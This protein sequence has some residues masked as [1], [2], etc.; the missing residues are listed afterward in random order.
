MLENAKK[1]NIVL[2]SSSAAN[3]KPSEAKQAFTKPEHNPDNRGEALN[4][5][6]NFKK[7]N[8]TLAEQ[9]ET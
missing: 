9:G 5:K 4:L 1:S 8:F 6:Q 7:P 3:F 2:G